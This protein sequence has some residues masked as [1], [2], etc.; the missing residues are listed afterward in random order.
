LAIREE[1]WAVSKIGQTGRLVYAI[2]VGLFGVAMA[3]GIVD[4]MRVNG[5]LPA[6]DL[7]T[8]GP[9]AYI[10]LLLAR[11]D[12]EGAIRELE[13]QTRIPPPDADAHALLGKLLVSQGRP[14]QA[15]AQFQTL[16]KLRPEDADGYCFLGYTYLEANQP[17]SADSAKHCFAKAIELN[18]QFSAA[19][20]GL[21]VALAQLGKMADAEQC[22]AKAVELTPDYVDAQIH[23][24][25]ARKELRAAPDGAKKGDTGDKPDSSH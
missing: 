8:S 3:A 17:N 13:I 20:N 14:E 21:G 7:L 19:F 5:R 24:E 10:Q 18:P 2:G 23:L 12:Y 11:K 16:V 1:N 22:F 9:K 15:Q 4:S 25:R 6:I